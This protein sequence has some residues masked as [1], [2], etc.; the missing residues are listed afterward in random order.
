MEVLTPDKI[1]LK[2][3]NSKEYCR[4]EFKINN[5]N[6]TIYKGLEIDSPNESLEKIEKIMKSMINI[7]NDTKVTKFYDAQTFLDKA[8]ENAGI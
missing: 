6:K 4:L 2:W 3:E 5:S 8:I 1:M 7:I